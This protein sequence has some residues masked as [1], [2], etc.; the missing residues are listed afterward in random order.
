MFKFSTEII[1]V[2]SALLLHSRRIAPLA[3]R[4]QTF[5]ATGGFKQTSLTPFTCS[6]AISDGSELYSKVSRMRKRR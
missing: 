4:I 5:A 2:F 3:I 1:T 6:G